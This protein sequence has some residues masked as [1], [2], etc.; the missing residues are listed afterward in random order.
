MII[1]DGASLSASRSSCLQRGGG[2][3][4]PNDVYLPAR[5]LVYSTFSYLSG[6]EVSGVD[7][8]YNARNIYEH[9]IFPVAVGSAQV[10]SSPSFFLGNQ[11]R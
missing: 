1:A 4:P 9:F 5:E 7:V 2:Q 11:E 6:F 3:I 8:C 10:S